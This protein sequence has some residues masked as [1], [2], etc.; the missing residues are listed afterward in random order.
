MRWWIFMAFL[1][2]SA[3]FSVSTN[4]RFPLMISG[5]STDIS[6]HFIIYMINS[7]HW[8][9]CFR[10]RHD[11][12]ESCTRTLHWN[13]ALILFCL[14][15]WPVF[16]YLKVIYLT[17]CQNN[18]RYCSKGHAWVFSDL[19]SFIGLYYFSH[20]LFWMCYYWLLWKLIW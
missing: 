6:K 5:P 19:I 13:Y 12:C 7:L 2:L 3:N 14:S 8:M 20:I 11:C 9:C 18:K 17:E 4:L 1:Q 15:L 10:W 16:I